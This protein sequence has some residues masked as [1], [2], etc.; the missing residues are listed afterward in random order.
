ML[1][2][3]RQK[4]Y[5]DKRNDEWQQY[6]HAFV[7]SR[8]PESLHQ[9]R[10]TLKKLK[11]LARFA[12]ACSGENTVK[13]FNGFKKMFKLAGEIRDARNHLQLLERLHS[14]PQ[15]YKDLQ[16]DVET[17]ATEKFIRRSKRYRRQGQ[18]AACRLVAG[19]S[20]IPASCIRDWY[21]LQLVSTG[22]LLTAAGDDLHKA[23]KQIKDLL[24]I[25][26][27]LPPPLRTELHLDRE[28]LDKLQDAIGQWHD[29]AV[30]ISEW[31]GKDLDSG[32]ALMQDVRQKEVVIHL[33]AEH[34]YLRVDALPAG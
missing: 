26:K 14:A 31:A 25:E 15:Q 28:Y 9:L 3:R 11:A 30:V 24:Y 5:L 23:R 17:T 32:Q 12:K 8:D 16:Q 19:I 10:V 1:S 18:R 13:D 7:D 29:A 6:L 4:Q 21:A 20:A 22:I 2:R 33:L 27:L 34:F